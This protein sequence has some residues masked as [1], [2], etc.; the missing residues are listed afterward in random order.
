MTNGTVLNAVKDVEGRTLTVSYKGQEKKIIVRE[1]VPI[2][3]FGPATEADLKPGGTVFVPA[4]EVR[5]AP[6]RLASLSSAR[7]E[8]TH[9]CNATRS[10]ARWR[11]I[12][13]TYL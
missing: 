13:V 12:F 6:F 7:T 8:P 10:K 11:P 3:T 1:G 9:R 4:H 2:V 5:T